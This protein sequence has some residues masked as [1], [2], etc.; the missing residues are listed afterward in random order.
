MKKKTKKKKR[1]SFFV[2]APTVG[3]RP[4]AWALHIPSMNRSIA[5]FDK[6]V[7]KMKDVVML[8]KLLNWCVAKD[9][10]KENQN[11]GD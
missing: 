11:H 10:K 4:S 7:F 6:D 1:A 5:M 3:A 9:I 2:I 8:V